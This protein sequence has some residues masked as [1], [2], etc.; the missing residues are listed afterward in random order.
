[1]LLHSIFEALAQKQ[2]FGFGFEPSN[3][4]ILHW[5]CNVIDQTFLVNYREKRVCFF[6]P[7]SN[8]I[9]I[10]FFCVF[11]ML[12]DV[13]AIQLLKLLIVYLK[14]TLLILFKY[15]LIYCKKN[16]KSIIRGKYTYL[17]SHIARYLK[18]KTVPISNYFVTHLERKTQTILYKN[19]LD[20]YIFVLLSNK[21]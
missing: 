4:I 5:T 20:K 15:E 8:H 21:N 11:T 1:M 2:N 16:Y 10:Y 19:V 17:L 9:F 18:K 7:A 14:K 6:I 3:E 12:Y 13:S